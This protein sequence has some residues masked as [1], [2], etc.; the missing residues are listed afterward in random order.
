MRIDME[1]RIDRPVEE[2][3]AAFTDLRSAPERVGGIERIEVLTGGETG[4]GT[5]FRETRKMFG[6]E[7]T[8]ELTFTE[9][10]PGRSYTLSAE[11]CGTEFSTRFRFSAE[12]GGTRVQVETRSRPV[13][14]AAKLLSPLGWLMARPMCKAFER[15]LD[16]LK[17]SI[18]GG[19]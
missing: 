11:S 12:D 4:E 19:G 2:V 6:K 13:T 18:E 5:R 3:F 17:S 14:F 1:R 10:D 16:D 7:A 8:E 9:F 15:D